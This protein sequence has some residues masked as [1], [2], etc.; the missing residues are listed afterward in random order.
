MTQ[1]MAKAAEKLSI[2]CH[3]PDMEVDED[4]IKDYVWPISNQERRGF[5]T[6]LAESF[7]NVLKESDNG[8]GRE[9]L[10]YCFMGTRFLVPIIALFQGDLLRERSITENLD[11]K[12]PQDWQ[13][14]PVL[15]KEKTPE[16]PAFLKIIQNGPEKVNYT[17]K[18]F[19]FSAVK[20][21]WKILSFK[22]SGLQLGDLKIKSVTSDVLKNSIVATQRSSLVIAHASEEKKEVVFCRS[23]R[24]FE[25]ISD[26][27]LEKSIELNNRILEK[28]IFDAIKSGYEKYGIE[29]KPH[30]I[31]FIQNLLS[32]GPAIMRIHYERLLEKTETLPKEIWTGTTGQYWDTMLRVAVMKNGGIAKAHDHGSGCAYVLYPLRGITEYWGCD[33]FVTFNRFNAEEITRDA[34]AYPRYDNKFPKFTSI[35][36]TG[37]IK[38]IKDTDKKPETIFYMATLYDNDRGRPGPGNTNNF[39]VDWGVRLSAFLKE[40][41]YKPVVKIHPE[42]KFMPPKFIEENLGVKVTKE[43]FTNIMQDADVV[44]FDCIFTTAFTDCLATDI[45]IVLIDFFGFPWTEK[46]KELIQ[47]RC[48][49]VEADYIDNRAQPNWNAIDQAIQQAPQKCKNHDFYETYFL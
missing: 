35:K 7:A 43:P 33:E 27:E 31:R 48:E 18:L 29:L 23:N 25:S 45:P 3:V 16:E 12:V 44:I 37:V 49:I 41:S 40:S 2:Q 19:K 8:D 30:S 22:K 11:I 34:K 39:I 38:R 1:A 21:L 28:K 10:P 9:T 6:H 36:P 14:W 20:R 24:W 4:G 13:Y 46:G 42:T 17:Q 47:K 32:K 5:A 15:L 26:E